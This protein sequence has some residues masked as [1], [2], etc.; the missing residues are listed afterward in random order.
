MRASPREPTLTLGK[1]HQFSVPKS[2]TDVQSLQFA[3][4]APEKR[5]GGI[6]GCQKS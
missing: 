2:Q 4:L 5:Q 6:V 1:E 3:H